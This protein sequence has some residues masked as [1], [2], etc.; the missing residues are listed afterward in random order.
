[1]NK[2]IYILIGII[3]VIL[4]LGTKFLNPSS[5]KIE[6]LYENFKSSKKKTMKKQ[7]KILKSKDTN[8]KLAEAVSTV[9]PQVTDIIP[10]EPKSLNERFKGLFRI[11][12]RKDNKSFQIKNNIPV[13]GPRNNTD[14]WTF[15]NT[16][17]YSFFDGLYLNYN[18]ENKTLFVTTSPPGSY[19]WIF[20][21]KGQLLWVRNNYKTLGESYDLENE[22]LPFN[23]FENVEPEK[24]KCIDYNYYLEKIGKPDYQIPE[25]NI[26]LYENLLYF[27]AKTEKIIEI[28]V[29]KTQKYS[30]IKVTVLGNPSSFSYK[31][32]STAEKI[33]IIVVVKKPTVIW[34]NVSV[35]AQ[36]NLNV[37][38]SAKKNKTTKNS[39]KQKPVDG[40]KQVE[41]DLSIQSKKQKSQLKNV[42]KE[43]KRNY[44]I[45][46]HIQYPNLVSK[47][48]SQTATEFGIE[49]PRQ[50]KIY[51][52]RDILTSPYYIK[53][54]Q[55]FL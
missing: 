23:V 16:Q 40:K 29:P 30:N 32:A 41:K 26:V 48:A 3:L 50:K 37:L 20:N 47:I 15:F 42:C 44:N 46:Y 28:P 14:L 10:T 17:L 4:V 49:D 11:F 45:Q 9:T 13:L 5:I 7:S 31:N 38:C 25:K 39:Q 54:F 19:S 18:K 43:P 53:K 27:T 34:V 52:C 36:D 12:S 8:S 6:H 35:R 21:S 24:K 2:T 55:Q 22:C 51:R 33:K 1:M